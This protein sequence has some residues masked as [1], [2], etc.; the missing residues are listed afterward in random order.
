MITSLLQLLVL[1]LH[2]WKR[3]RTMDLD[4]IHLKV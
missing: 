3:P 1:Q 2:I 4:I